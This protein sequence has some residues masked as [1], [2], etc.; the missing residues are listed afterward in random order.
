MKRYC[1]D[2]KTATRCIER[3]LKWT[4]YKVRVK[5]E[6]GFQCPW[7]KKTPY[8]HF[9]YRVSIIAPG[10]ESTWF[11]FWGPVAG[12]RENEMLPAGEMIAQRIC[13]SEYGDMS[14][15]EFASE[16]GYNTDSISGL[17]IWRTCIRIRKTCDRLFPARIKEALLHCTYEM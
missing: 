6:A 13:D 11:H 12:Y 14:F 16:C 4:G 15:E 1:E 17:K 2:Y 9:R 5:R 3:V 7:D 10:G 8:D